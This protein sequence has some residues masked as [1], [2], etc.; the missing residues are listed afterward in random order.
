MALSEKQKSELLTLVT[1]QLSELESEIVITKERLKNMQ[2]S[3][4]LPIA[5]PPGEDGTSGHDQ[6]VA[7][8]QLSALKTQQKAL[9]PVKMRL[10]LG[11]Y[12]GKCGLCHKPINFERL[13]ALPGTVSCIECAEKL[14]APTRRR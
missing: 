1:N 2:E 13:R 8:T 6:D 7:R 14:Q 10:E 11:T 4:L 5:H 12:T 9:I 3:A